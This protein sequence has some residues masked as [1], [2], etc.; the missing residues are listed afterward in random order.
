MMVN[1]CVT[2]ILP[3]FRYVLLTD[4]L[5]DSLTPL[6]VAAVFGH[7][8]GHIAH[9]HLLYF[10]FFFLGSLGVLSILA[11]VV[12]LAGPYARNW[13]RLTPWT[14]AVVSEMFQ[15]VAL[16]DALGLY[17]W[18]VFGQLSRRFER[19]ADVFGSK[20]V[21]CDLADCPPH[22]DLDHELSP[23]PDLV[24]VPQLCPVGIR[25]FADALA[26]VARTNGLDPNGRSWR[27]G[28][29]A[30]RI[31]FLE[32]LERH[33]EREQRFS[34]GRPAAPA[35]TRHRPGPGDLVLGRRLR[36]GIAR[37]ED[38]RWQSRAAYW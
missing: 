8:I 25:I 33:P 17:F 38:R 27:H 19:Q 29:I 6:E 16:L 13:P 35:R 23:P 11:E 37:A 20:V 5:I 31:A 21:S 24:A 34:T 10:A 3:G 26:N 14:P 15:G 22:T 36:L 12:S 28:S 18:I 4:A 9:R 7:E 32:G 1:A 30:H 2:G